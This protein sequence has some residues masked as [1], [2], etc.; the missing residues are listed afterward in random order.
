MTTDDISDCQEKPI[1]L[2]FADGCVGIDVRQTHPGN[3]RGSSDA[4]IVS[5]DY[6]QPLHGGPYL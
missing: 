4:S 5:I 6:T 3:Q 1:S 2:A